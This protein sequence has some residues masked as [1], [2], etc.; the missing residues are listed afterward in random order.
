MEGF[1]IFP[2]VL[3]VGVKKRIGYLILSGIFAS[4]A[5]LAW[6]SYVD[7]SKEVVYEGKTVLPTNIA[8][9]IMAQYGDGNYEIQPVN[10]DNVLLEYRLQ[11]KPHDN[12]QLLDYHDNNGMYGLLVIPIGISVFASLIALIYAIIPITEGE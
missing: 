7:L 3:K 12:L 9:S 6:V 2:T 5:W 1:F 10:D 8:L 11:R 4:L